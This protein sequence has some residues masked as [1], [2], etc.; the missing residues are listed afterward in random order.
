M[1]FVFQLLQ[2]DL[3]SVNINCL[4]NFFIQFL[5]SLTVFF[6]FFANAIKRYDSFSSESGDV[7]RDYAEEPKLSSVP[8]AVSFLDFDHILVIRNHLLPSMMKPTKLIK[9]INSNTYFRIMP[10]GL[11]VLVNLVGSLYF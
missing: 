3:L 1:K 9:L 5:N 8:E 7:P 6:F 11:E 2:V 10:S 4:V